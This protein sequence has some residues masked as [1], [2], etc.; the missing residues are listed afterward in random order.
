M[1]RVSKMWF[2]SLSSRRKVDWQ[3]KHIV[4]LCNF[5]EGWCDFTQE[6]NDSH[7]LLHSGPTP[8]DGTGPTFDHST[9]SSKGKCSSS[10]NRSL[11]MCSSALISHRSTPATSL[12]PSLV[13]SIHPLCP[14]HIPPYLPALLLYLP[15][16]QTDGKWCKQ[17]DICADRQANRLRW[18]DGGRSRRNLIHLCSP[19]CP[20]TFFQTADPFLSFQGPTFSLKPPRGGE[21]IVSAS[22][23][24]FLSPTKQCAFSSGITCTA[25]ILETSV[26]SRGPTTLRDWSGNKVGSRETHGRSV[27]R[28]WT[29]P[30]V[31]R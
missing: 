4:G 3:A 21:G 13:P 31:S 22:W 11:G 24:G 2:V 1:F 25:A 6:R 14:V 17:T 19:T 9:F 20:L 7:W 12:P 18:T 29:P 27:K 30:R 16:R 15:E 26:W 23:A 5:E 8:S 28:R 10:V